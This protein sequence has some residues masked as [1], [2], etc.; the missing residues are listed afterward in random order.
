MFPAPPNFS[1]AVHP[2][3]PFGFGPTSPF[4]NAANVSQGQFLPQDPL[5]QGGDPTSPELLKN[6]VRLI[7]QQVLELQVFARRVLANMYA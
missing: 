5:H 4:S 3:P 7:H 6:N 1:A 2:I